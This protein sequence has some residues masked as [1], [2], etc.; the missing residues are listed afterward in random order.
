MLNAFLG[1]AAA[2]LV[3]DSGGLFQEGAQVIGFSLD[4][5]RD[6]ACSMME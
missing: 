5:A 2:F 6:G 4:Q 3:R 1:F